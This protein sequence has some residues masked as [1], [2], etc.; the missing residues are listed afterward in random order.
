VTTP[1]FVNRKGQTE[2]SPVEILATKHQIPV[3]TSMPEVFADISPDFEADFLIT[4]G[5]GRLLPVSL[6]SEPKIASLNLHFSV[7]PK[8][9]GA[10]P[11]EWAILMNEKESGISII[12]MNEKFDQGGV[13]FTAT[14][15]LSNQETRESLYEKLYL[16]G[17]EHLPAVIEQVKNSQ[18]QPKPQPETDLP[19]AS[20][21]KR[22]D[23]FVAWEA[24]KKL[25]LGQSAE[26]SLI[27]PKLQQIATLQN[28]QTLD[29][30]Y[31]ERAT[32]ALKDF[33]SLWTIVPTAKG[34]KR[35]KLHK[36]HLQNNQLILD[37]VQIEGQTRSLW[38]QVKNQVT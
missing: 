8:Y 7:L 37:E 33:P 35:M 14:A 21:F 27:S 5:Y 25:M 38:N 3:T 1:A 17:G 13:L 6:L 24:V 26:L 10:N 18:L 16:L 20:R 22:E 34:E 36:A 32:R 2:Q 4:A 19:Y 23:G 30:S 12:E 28:L 31:L 11:G 9:R 29:G 15:A